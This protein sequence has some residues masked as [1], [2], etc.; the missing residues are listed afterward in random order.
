MDELWSYLWRKKT[1]VWIWI[2]LDVVTRL[3]IMEDAKNRYIEKYG[4][5][6]ANPKLDEVCG[7]LLPTVRDFA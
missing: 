6:T 4:V 1:K 7:I 3:F 2:G 5:D